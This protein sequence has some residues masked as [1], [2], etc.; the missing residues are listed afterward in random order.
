[1]RDSRTN[2]RY[3]VT[4]KNNPLHNKDFYLKETCK[5]FKTKDGYTVYTVQIGSLSSSRP[6][7]EK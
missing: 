5:P 3:N 4:F 6:T 1:M 2:V 7:E